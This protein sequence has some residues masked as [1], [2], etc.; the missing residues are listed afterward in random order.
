MNRASRAVLSTAAI[1]L[2]LVP[3]STAGAR[4]HK[5]TICHKGEEISIAENAVEAHLRNHA[6][7]QLGW[8]NVPPT[9]PGLSLPGAVVPF[10]S[11]LVCEVAQ[12]AV[13]PD[14][15]AITYVFEWRLNDV[16]FLDT[17]TT[18]HPGDTVSAE[19]VDHG[20]DSS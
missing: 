20:E 3:V 12:P 14:G 11:D 13:D 15:D 4:N 5:V 10:D 8:C 1:L 9:M 6:G 2:A 19:L 17:A 7:D 16:L 18:T